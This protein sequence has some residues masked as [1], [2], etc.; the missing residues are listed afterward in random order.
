MP[1]YR[2]LFFLSFLSVSPLV[3]QDVLFQSSFDDDTGFTVLRGA[4]D[5]EVTFGYD[6]A[7]FDGIPE[8]PSFGL[9]S[10]DARTGLKLEANLFANAPAAV[11]V[12]TE[13]LELSGRFDVQL[14]VWLNYNFPAGGNGTTENGGLG[15]GHDGEFGGLNGASF[16]YNS[17]GDTSRDYV[18]YKDLNRQELDTGQYA[19]ESWNNSDS[20]FVEVFPSIDL[21]EAI[22]E[23]QVVGVTP[24]G[25]GG[26][27]WMTINAEVDTDASGPAGETD[28]KGTAKF[29]ITDNSSGN[30]VEIGTIDNSTG[31]LVNLS[32]NVSVL[33]ADLFASV[34]NDESLSF[35]IFDNLIITAAEVTPADP[36]DCNM[37]GVVDSGDIAC[38]TMD[39]IGDTLVASNTLAGD[40]D[41]NGSV[42]FLDFLTLA[43]NFRVD[44][45]G[46]DYSRGD[47]DLSGAVDFID[48]IALANNFGQNST[49]AALNP[50]PT[51]FALL[52]LPLFLLGQTRRRRYL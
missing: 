38:A 30:S 31:D 4:D 16:I 24:A 11:A 43:E 26:F 14:D 9:T 32:G 8:S 2:T 20:D 39:T 52:A 15:I 22:P 35:G 5:T 6:Y 37:D 12:V 44:E 45:A 28:G 21:E 10:G 17:D 40:F 29:T 46:G 13:G 34:S 25:S 50:E 23:Q 33:F 1:L 18:L 49:A 48:F 51:G 19:I 27:R 47:S 36:L 7:D 41:L 3:A 42:D